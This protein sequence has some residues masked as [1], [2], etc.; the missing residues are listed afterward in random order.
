MTTP[1]ESME[2][3]FY[4]EFCKGGVWIAPNMKG[5]YILQFIRSYGDERE[6]KAWEEIKLVVD[7]KKE[8]HEMQCA[9]GVDHAD[10]AFAEILDSITT[11]LTELS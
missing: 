7:Y 4:E 2:E 3:N 9:K 11:K 10:T 5:E 6:R 8:V 1:E